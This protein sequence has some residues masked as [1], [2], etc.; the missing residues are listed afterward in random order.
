MTDNKNS[1]DIYKG[2]GLTGLANCGNSCY[3]NSCMQIISHTYEL[4]DFLNNEN[5]KKKL[6]NNADSILLLEWDKLRE[7]MWS[8]NC[9]ISPMGYVCAVKKVAL[10]KNRDLFTDSSQNDI[11]EFILFIIDSFH[12]ALSR[13]VD[14][15]V[16]GLPTNNMDKLAQSCYKMM[17]E[18]YHKNFS[19][20]LDIFNGIHISTITANNDVLSITP[21]PFFAINLSIP[22][23]KTP[24]IY[25]CFDHY[26]K[27]E[28]LTGENAW[29]NE[30]TN[31]KQDVEKG[32]V[33]WN[34]PKILI[35]D[36]KRWDEHGRKI[37]TKVNAPL[38]ELNLSKYVKGYYPETYVYD[39]YGVCNH[40]GGNDGG[41]YTAYIKNANEK[42]YEFNDTFVTEI[43]T[44][45]IIT[46][47]SYCFFY[48]K[49]NNRINI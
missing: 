11:Q 38:E 33:F 34:L 21:E 6:N 25:D 26:C 10:L 8:K 23:I 28:E 20:I 13:E 40:Y 42:W 29:F 46:Q 4:N 32:I 43:S 18:M 22:K 44:S 12:S 3:L 14:M 30:K 16:V 36:L 37:H 35:I 49:K 45:K 41:H 1:F 7:L 17:C 5:Y 19:E 24:S 9:I 2:C 47:N 39:L 48:R 15:Q 31:E 27:R